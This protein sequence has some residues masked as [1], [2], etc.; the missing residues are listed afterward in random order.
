[1]RQRMKKS[2]PIY[3]S[4]SEGCDMGLRGD[5]EVACAGLAHVCVAHSRMLQ[6]LER[7][8]SPAGSE[9]LE[10]IAKENDG[11]LGLEAAQRACATAR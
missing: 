4:L 2:D 10:K 3:S 7:V 9:Y 5:G 1:M 8:S 6:T 11:H